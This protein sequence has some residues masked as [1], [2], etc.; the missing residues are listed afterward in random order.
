MKKF[1][2]RKN[3]IT[4]I[5][6]VVTIIILL[7]LA[8]ISIN[9]AINGGIIKRTM[10]SKEKSEIAKEKETISISGLTVQSGNEG[11]IT[12]SELENEINTELNGETTATV[13]GNGPF[14]IKYKNSGRIYTL[15]GDLNG[16]NLLVDIENVNPDGT[17]KWESWPTVGDGTQDKPYQIQS[18]EDLTSFAKKVADSTNNGFSGKY[19]ELKTNLDFYYEGYY[20][21]SSRKDFG[22]INGDGTVGSLIEELTTSNG[23]APIGYSYNYDDATESKG[24]WIQKD[25][26]GNF[27]GNGNTI[28]NL[29]IYRDNSKYNSCIGFFGKCTS[30]NLKGIKLNNV[31]INTVLCSDVGGIVGLYDSTDENISKISDCSVSGNIIAQGYAGGIIGFKSGNKIT[32]SNCHNDANIKFAND[33]GGIVGE[34]QSSATIENC[35]N[36]GNLEKNNPLGAAGY[37]GGIAGYT[38]GYSKDAIKATNCYNTGNILSNSHVGGIFGR[39]SGC[40]AEYCYNTGK[41]EAYQGLGGIMGYSEGSYL[42]INHCYNN[43]EIVIR[44]IDPKITWDGAIDYVGGIAGGSATFNI[45]YSYNTG[46]I[47]AEEIFNKS[48]LY[49]IGGIAGECEECD[50]CYNIGNIELSTNDTKDIIYNMPSCISGISGSD[51]KVSNVYNLG[52]IVINSKNNIVNIGKHQ[53][54]CISGI[55]GEYSKVSNAY[56]LGKI[57]INNLQYL[58]VGA[59]TGNNSTDNLANNFFLKG[60]WNFGIGSYDNITNTDTDTTAKQVDTEEEMKSKMIAYFTT[61]PNWS[62]DANNTNNG[63]PVLK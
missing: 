59:I 13:H 52:N 26:S 48:T 54:Y 3:G 9:I 17:K 60:T 61:Q 56:N 45:S 16:V 33:C 23:W 42:Y 11:K 22:D 6:L 2:M 28:S 27:I 62:T 41:I 40:T 53:V 20:I 25:F 14:Y 46:N 19:I 43:G 63:Y 51:S 49:N 58:S 15:N 31:N 50:N 18:I 29:Y 47:K 36:T 24:S 10:D 32:I 5:A 8:G 1:L 44:K 35:Y 39:A 12:S 34:L 38:G 4:L 57:S 7:I 21:D 37:V 30:A 55:S